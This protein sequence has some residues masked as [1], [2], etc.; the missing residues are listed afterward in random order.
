MRAIGVAV[1]VGMLAAGSALADQATFRQGVNG[2]EGVLGGWLYW[3]NPDMQL[4]NWAE[5]SGDRLRNYAASKL[6]LSYLGEHY[7]GNEVIS[8]LVADD[9]YGVGGIDR[10][11]QSGGYSVDFEAVFALGGC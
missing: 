11:L 4:T 3:R 8:K 10:F 1:V 7:G 9:A 6:F 5:D 2:Y